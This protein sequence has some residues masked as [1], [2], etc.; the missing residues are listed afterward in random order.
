[1]M[2]RRAIPI[3]KP[4]FDEREIKATADV[5]LSG[6]IV[7]GPKVME[8]ERT[9][10]DF[11]GCKHAIATTSATASLHLALIALGIRAGDEVIVPAFTHPSTANMVRHVG[12][13]PVFVD[14]T[15]PEFNI[16]PLKIEEKITKKT[17]AIIPV[18]LFGLP[19]DMDPILELARH[20]KLKVVEDAACALGTIYKGRKVGVIGQCGAFSFHPRKSIT[21]GEGGMVTT[22]DKEINDRV[23][24]LRSHGESLSD[25]F[26]HRSDEVVYP[27]F[28][29]LGFNYR[30][31]D[32]QAAIG[33]EQ[34]KKLPD[35]LEARRKIASRYDHLLSGL[36]KDESILLP[37]RRDGFIHSYQSYV[38]LLMDRVSMERDKLSN[39]LQK[40][41]IA[42]RK[43]TYHVPG[44]KVYRESFSFK[45]NTLRNSMMADER[46]LAL[47]LYAG[48]E[49]IDVNYVIERFQ[50][51]LEDEHQTF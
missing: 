41:G 35:M 47:P 33:V 3:A 31:T 43:G 20:F 8:F 29:L 13:V 39:E 34:M 50:A 23:R 44:I 14:V 7:Q 46:S 15:L 30:M 12:A 19:A 2:K 26:R 5:L 10:E 32:I 11:Q 24:M 4:C 9:M 48:M 22:N 17:K 42:T 51:I 40:R 18:H 21:T 16:D 37:P 6:W 28:E 36:E 49:E 1:M 38:I 27:D 25:E 45:K